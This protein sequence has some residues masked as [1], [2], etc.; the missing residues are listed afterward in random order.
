MKVAV[1]TAHVPFVRGGAELL[2]EGLHRAL[3]G[4]GVESEI[5]ALPFHWHPPSRL[6]DQLVAAR[7]WRVDAADRVIGLKF[8]ACHVQHPAKVHWLLHQHRP[9]YDLWGHRM[10]GLPESVEGRSIRDAVRRADDAWL[11]EARRI[12]TISAVVSERLQRFNGLA[13]TVLHPPLDA[14]ERFRSGDLGDY[15]VFPSRLALNKRQRLVVEAMRH[16][17]SGLRL[18]LAGAAATPAELA[19]VRA[20]VRRHGVGD[21]VTVLGRWVPE[22]ELIELLA[23]ARGVVF[24]PFDEDYGYVT[25]EAAASARAVVTCTDSGGPLEFVVDGETGLVADPTPTS[26]AAAIDRLGHDRM[27]ARRLGEAARDRLDALGLSWD[28][29]VETLLA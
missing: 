24:T 28:H 15:V 16:V 17:R 25:L 8:P 22:P 12:H 9:A 19:A 18:V 23:G 14:P 27:L 10:G 21:R 4:H 1:V 6:L 5:V 7:T 26:I 2:A 29:V 11:P 13:S 20:E 3:L